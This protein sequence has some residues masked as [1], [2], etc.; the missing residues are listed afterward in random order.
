MH[1]PSA[2]PN[3]LMIVGALHVDDI[4]TTCSPLI[5]QASNPVTWAHHIGGVAAN[6]AFSAREIAHSARQIGFC[7]A[8]GNDA[9]ANQLEQALITA[10]LDACLQRLPDYP[11]GRYTAIMNHD[12]ELHIGLSDVALA[13]RLE[14]DCVP[15]G[16]EADP[17][18]ALLMDAN[19]SADCL[20][21]L[22]RRAAGMGIAVA[23]M[24]VSPVKSRRLLPLASHIDLLFVNRRE[25]IALIDRNVSLDLPIE[26]LADGLSE[27]GFRQFILTDA[28]DPVL[29]QDGSTRQC[30]PVPATEDRV[31]VNGAGDALAGACFAAWCDGLTLA[32]AVRTV[33]LKQSVSVV[34]G[35][36]RPP[37]VN[38]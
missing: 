8:T 38:G 36:R 26:Q 28:T 30:I 16:S 22:A 6:A 17:C 14:A 25:A 23:A 35:E 2:S 20:A 3:R 21:R 34:S 13:E 33:G 5:A 24:S 32:D 37:T 15:L 18:Q 7:A 19:L 10:G 4:A 31:S 11:T 9:V 1:L 27:L 12:G 29:V